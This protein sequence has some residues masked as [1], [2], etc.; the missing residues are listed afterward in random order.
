MQLVR[1]GTLQL[2]M[3]SSLLC[4][5]SL[6]T[7]VHWISCCPLTALNL[8]CC[9]KISDNGLKEISRCRLT[10]LDLSR[11]PLI[12][13]VGLKEICRCPLTKLDLSGC[14]ISDEGVKAISRCPLTKLDLRDCAITS[15]G[16]KEISR[17]P[18]TYLN[19]TRRY[20]RI[21]NNDLEDFFR[22]LPGC[23]LA[24]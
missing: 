14:A 10:A 17:C 8:C 7:E 16:L 21:T 24:L 2:V 22:C 12:T 13:D 3:F 5:G 20:R 9:R 6:L 1:S 18:L 4:T 15:E 11:C 23:T 19:L